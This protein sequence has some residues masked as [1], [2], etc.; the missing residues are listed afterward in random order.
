MGVPTKMDLS[1]REN[2]R[3][4]VCEADSA[5][6]MGVQTSI[7]WAVGY[8]VL[9][10][11][12]EYSLGKCMHFLKVGLMEAGIVGLPNV[13]KSTLFNALTAAGIP[14]ENYPFCTI[15]PNVGVIS[16]P[17][18]RLQR[19]NK[20]I[21]AQKS[22]RPSSGWSISLAWFAE[23]RKGRVRQQVSFAHSRG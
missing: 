18:D 21:P 1:L 10:R 12:L 19:I 6:K 17:D 14:S 23:H 2:D 15:E 11:I 3:G 7:E 5:A 16:V 4:P 20:L 22:C 13:G 9:A 8:H